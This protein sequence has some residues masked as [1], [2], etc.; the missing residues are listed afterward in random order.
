MSATVALALSL[1]QNPL[2]QAEFPGISMNGGTLFGLPVIVSEYV[3]VVTASTDPV[4][5]G[6]YVVLVNASD[7][8]FADDGDVA[9]DLSREAS[10]EMADN[11]AHNSG[12]PTPAQLVSMFQTNSVAFRAERTLNWMARRANA[13]QV[14]SAV[15]WGQ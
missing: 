12:T 7:I 8:Y 10:L 3:P 13:V 1:M 6:A 9:V 14:L 11:P 4:D 5:D 15:K 2:G